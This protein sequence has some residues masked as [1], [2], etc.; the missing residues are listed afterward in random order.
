MDEDEVVSDPLRDMEMLAF[1]GIKDRI[2]SLDW[3]EMQIWLPEFYAVW[4]I[5]RRSHLREPIGVKT[6][7]LHLMGSVLKIRVSSLK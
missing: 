6:L 1:E 2:N 5:K 3:D 4:A 7:L